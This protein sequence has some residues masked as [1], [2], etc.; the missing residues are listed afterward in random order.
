MFLNDIAE[1]ANEKFQHAGNH[2]IDWN[3]MTRWVA[4]IVL[5]FLVLHEI[6]VRNERKKKKSQQPPLSPKG[7]EL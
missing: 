2:P 4:V 6:R 7:A 1:S 5:A 3:T